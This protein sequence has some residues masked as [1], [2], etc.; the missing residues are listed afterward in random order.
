MGGEIQTTVQYRDAATSVDELRRFLASQLVEDVDF[1]VIPGTK[2][3]KLY[4]EGADKVLML[5]NARPEY[6]VERIE[7]GAGGHVEYLVQC[8]VVSRATDRPISEGW[9]SCS[10][11]EERYRFRTTE[12]LCPKCNQPAII[13]SK[14]E[15]GGGWYCLPGKGGCKAKF[16]ADD[17]AVRP[18]GKVEA[19]D[20]SD[21][22]NTVLQMACKRARVKAVEGFVCLEPVLGAPQPPREPQQEPD[23]VPQAEEPSA[24]QQARKPARS[25][26]ERIDAA[27]EHYRPKFAAKFRDELGR[28]PSAQDAPIATPDDVARH[29]WD[30]AQKARWVEADRGAPPTPFVALGRLEDVMD[31]HG[32]E[33]VREIKSLIEATQRQLIE[34][35]KE[36]Q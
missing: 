6:E 27:L 29:L 30:H 20:V 15:Y 5:S 3:K 22:R 12:R 8:R 13:R 21:Q 34:E 11:M 17:K 23:V 25:L 4:Q 9:G 16:D 19:E 18:G 1:G 14:P 2:G 10:T 28:D 32:E 24:P 35:A 7:R 33:M 31:R 36:Q 26:K